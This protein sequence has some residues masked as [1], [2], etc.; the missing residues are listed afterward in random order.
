[1]STFPQIT[2]HPA[3][4][5]KR[6]FSQHVDPF[7]FTSGQEFTNLHRGV[8]WE[9]LFG[10]NDCIA[11]ISD[12][13]RIDRMIHSRPIETT[14]QLHRERIQGSDRKT[15][16]ANVVSYI[17]RATEQLNQLQL[18]GEITFTKNQNMREVYIFNERVVIRFYL[19]DISGFI[20]TLLTH[21]NRMHLD[22]IG[23]LGRVLRDVL[24]HRDV[25]YHSTIVPRELIK[26]D[27]SD[28]DSEMQVTE[29]SELLQW[30]P[31]MDQD[32]VNWQKINDSFQLGPPEIQDYD[33]LRWADQ[34][35]CDEYNDEVQHRYLDYLRERDLEFVEA[36]DICKEESKILEDIVSIIQTRLAPTKLKRE[37]AGDFKIARSAKENIQFLLEARDKIAEIIGEY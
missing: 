33:P 35:E 26:A 24:F 5:K 27:C 34:K 6:V 3:F 1:M 15:L 8:N 21:S 7:D 19:C 10:A 30:T 20:Y 18:L 29:E 2:D 28:S 31:L 11:Y 9:I 36:M 17:T 32:F 25:A 14:E 16:R 22:L 37:V 12:P 13:D 23:E 4:L